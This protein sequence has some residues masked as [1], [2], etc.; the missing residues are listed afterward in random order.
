[1]TESAARRVRGA[2][3]HPVVDADGHWLEA[4]PVF[5]QFLDE[6]AGP[7]MVDQVVT[8]LKTQVGAWYGMTPADRQGR[9][10][11]RPAGWAY[12]ART[13]TRAASMLPGLYYDRLDD[14]G[15][16][17]ALVYPSLGLLFLGLG[18]ETMR[19]PLVRAYN[20]MIA[21]V[22][23]PYSDRII[24]AA[25]CTMQTPGEAIEEATYAVETLGLRLAV[26]NGTVVRPLANPPEGAAG[27]VYVDALGL[28]A[29]YD[30]DPVWSTFSRLGLAVT[31]HAGSISWP[32]R[33]SPTN[34]VANHLGHFAQGNQA[35]ARSLFMGGVTERH[36]DLRFGFLEG[37][38]GWACTLY[39]ELIGHWKKRNR[40]LLDAH[41]KPDLL[42]R[43]E[44]R[45][46]IDHYAGRDTRF[47]GLADR[48]ARDNLDPLEPDQSLE[49]LTQRDM[50]LDE[51]ENVRI[52]GEADFRRLFSRNFYFGCEADDPATPWA[53]SGSFEDA[54]LKPMLGSDISH[55]DVTEPTEVLHEA[56]EMVEHGWITEP[57]F[58]KFTFSHVVELHTGMNPD[59]FKGTV[60]EAR[61][62]DL[63]R[64]TG[65]NGRA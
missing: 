6:T 51:S 61:V 3:T 53:F 63:A 19:R 45:G 10:A 54:G 64:V 30:Y 38:V 12:S 29:A 33:N 32:D 4:L 36:P 57:Q 2:L 18:D 46:L 41:F 44:L 28:D 20:R 8:F 49:A 42:D 7:R 34:F 60:V 1:M 5:L 40:P 17:V 13:Q 55:F 26:V 52:D 58:E 15:I 56:W 62:A 48:I 43:A 47:R 16:D 23:A 25:I 39:S 21:E 37:G 50:D 27:R 14:W 35:F 24:P 65:N 11:S 59:F 31:N 22:F 9:R